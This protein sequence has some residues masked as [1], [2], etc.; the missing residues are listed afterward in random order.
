MDMKE[1]PVGEWIEAQYKGT[2][3]QGRVAS[4]NIST[5][6]PELVIYEVRLTSPVVLKGRPGGTRYE[7][8]YL[9][10]YSDEV[11]RLL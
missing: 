5:N 11:V 9:S 6:D 10:V 3:V 1:I 7:G 2:L 8:D 4:S